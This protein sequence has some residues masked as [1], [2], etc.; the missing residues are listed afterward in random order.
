MK[1]TEQIADELTQR[2]AEAA[3]AYF[4]DKPTMNISDVPIYEAGWR[5]GYDSGYDAAWQNGYDNAIAMV[6]ANYAKLQD[7]ANAD[8]N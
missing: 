8:H 6:K 5:A 3:K 4:R 1:T 7:A 2:A